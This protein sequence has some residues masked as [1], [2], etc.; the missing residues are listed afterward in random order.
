[1]TDVKMPQLGESVTEGTIGK[2][3]K[4]VGD[5]VSRHEPLLE[6]MTDKVNAEIPSEW[7]GVITEILVEEGDTVA[8]GTVICRIDTGSAA[9]DAPTDD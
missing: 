7:A 2:W 6:V 5:Y 8:V 9:D 3:L 1:M 4:Q